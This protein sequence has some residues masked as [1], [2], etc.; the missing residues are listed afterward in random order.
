MV[1]VVCFMEFLC[2]AQPSFVITDPQIEL[3]GN[4]IQISYEILNSKSSELFE[5]GLD[6]SDAEGNRIDAATLSGD[7]GKRVSGGTNKQIRWDLEADK[8]IRD[9]KIYFEIVARSMPQTELVSIG[10]KDNWEEPVTGENL[11]SAVPPIKSLSKNFSSASIFF[12]SL[13]I[14]GLGLSRVTGNPHWLRGLT[15]YGCMAGSIILNRVS[16]NT[17][18]G[19]E[20]YTGFDDKYSQLQ[21]SIRQDEISEILGYAAIGIW[22]TDILWTVAGISAFKK[23]ALYGKIRG[24][25]IKPGIDPLTYAPSIGLKFSF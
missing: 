22:A 5:V 14:P 4:A 18:K 6:I 19:I 7:I 10:R 3:R 20:D 8:I 11:S 1:L 16:F 9:E 23:R 17:Y 2:S 12:Q 13:A 25:A 21:K 24:I 15:G